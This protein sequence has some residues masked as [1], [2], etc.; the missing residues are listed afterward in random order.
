[1]PEVG[2]RFSSETVPVTSDVMPICTSVRV[3]SVGSNGANVTVCD[4][5][6]GVSAMVCCWRMVVSVAIAIG[7][8]SL[9][10]EF[11]GVGLGKQ[12]NHV[13]CQGIA[14]LPCGFVSFF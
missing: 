12:A 2:P 4:Q 8:W 1:M 11:K 6:E 13:E 9:G 14:I 10:W 3:P 5:L 7:A